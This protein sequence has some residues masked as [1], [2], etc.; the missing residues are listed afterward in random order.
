MLRKLQPGSRGDTSLEVTFE[1]SNEGTLSVRARDLQTGLREE[2]QLEARPHLPGAEV[3]RLGKEQAAYAQKQAETDARKSEDKFRKLLERGEKLAQALSR[4]VEEN[5]GE[6]AEA[7]V[8]H[9]RGLLDSGR[10]ALEAQDAARC[11]QV[12]RE[13]HP[14]AVLGALRRQFSSSSYLKMLGWPAFTSMVRVMSL[15]RSLLMSR[16]VCSPGETW[17]GAKGVCPSAVPSTN[18]VA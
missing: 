16:T 15:P 18:T 6:Q 9:V 10:S 1:L 8:A 7:A 14:V 3:E 12:A 4:G 13:P 17:M 11:A 2:L 5:P